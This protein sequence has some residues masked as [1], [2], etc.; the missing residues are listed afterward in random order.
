MHEAS[1]AQDLLALVEGTAHAH[2]AIAVTS[3]KIELGAL[4]CVSAEALVFAFAA[5]RRGTIAEHCELV[6]ERTPLVVTCPT[7]GVTG[8]TDATD[9]C[10]PGCGRGP[11]EVVGGREMRLVSIDVEDDESHA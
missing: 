3:A 10:C 6:I 11:V 9:P 4:S 2:S 7:C 8:A 5:M 1:L